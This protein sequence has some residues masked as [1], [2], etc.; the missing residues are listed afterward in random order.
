MPQ[1]AQAPNGMRYNSKGQ[2]ESMPG[3]Q[4]GVE[5]ITG[6]PS[7]YP[8]NGVDPSQQYDSA[9]RLAL[10]KQGAEQ[11]QA[12]SQQQYDLGQKAQDAMMG[13]LPGLMGAV[14]GGSTGNVQYPGGV[15]PQQSQAA[16]EAEFARAKDKSGQI[17]KSAL[18]G[19]SD[20]MSSRG[21]AGSGAQGE[22]AAKIIGGQ[23]GGLADLNREQAIQGLQ[24]TQHANDTQYQGDITQ[25][26][27]NMGMVQSLLGLLRS[28]VAY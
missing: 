17:A 14:G 20:N 8:L 4:S 15:S 26:A 24:Y 16:V 21:M 19:L 28:G 3:G 5:P 12:A 7:A 25:R 2:L 10:S 9:T 23:A 13:R 18:T 22:E 1:G 11:G 27:Q 6:A